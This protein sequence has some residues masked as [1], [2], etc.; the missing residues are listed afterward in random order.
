M[1]LESRQKRNEKLEGEMAGLMDNTLRRMSLSSVVPVEISIPEDSDKGEGSDGESVGEQVE[2]GGDEDGE[3]VEE[4][5]DVEDAEVVEE[6][7]ATGG[8]VVNI[9]EDALCLFSEPGP[10]YEHFCL[11]FQDNFNLF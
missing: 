8:V 6:M 4:G 3:K 9:Q 11:E 2:G 1:D 7:G 5:G 10:F